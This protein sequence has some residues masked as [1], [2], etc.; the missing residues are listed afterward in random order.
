MLEARRWR[1]CPCGQLHGGR[2]TGLWS[3]VCGSFHERRLRFWRAIARGGPHCLAAPRLKLR[4]LAPAHLRGAGLPS[5]W[6]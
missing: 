1:W 3:R 2:L 4:G 5:E 6:G